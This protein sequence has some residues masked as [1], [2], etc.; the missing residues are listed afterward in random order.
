MSVVTGFAHAS[1]SD[2]DPQAGDSLPFL[3]SRKSRKYMG[4]QD[5][6]AV[7]AAGRALAAAGLAG[8]SMGERTGL[9]LAIGY[10]PFEESDILP[11]LDAS[12]EDG[13][14]SMR[15]FAD[16][17]YQMGRPLLTFRCL[18]NMPAYHVSVNF[19][20]RGPYLVTY[21]AAGQ[22]ALALEEARAALRQGEIDVAL[23]GAV[24]HQR[25][26]LVEHHF[27]RL[28]PPVDRHRLRDI[29]AFLV[30]ESAAH[31]TERG[32]QVRGRLCALEVNYQTF[33]PESSMPAQ[34]E[35]F[36]ADGASLSDARQLGPASLPV[37]L[38]EAWSGTAPAMRLS[39]QVS[40]RDGLVATSTWTR[41]VAR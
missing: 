6:L 41:E 12:M 40:T 18:P 35:R 3:K 11:V 10:I 36:E 23:V 31:A 7:V 27:A 30:L 38:S 1:P 16:G 9:Y 20:V 13:R 29:G 14:F 25:N 4:V 37:W 21:P 26:F 33:D 15:R 19:G 5:E 34:H 24:A 28:L 2:G 22:F 32:A 17:G 39:H 8:K